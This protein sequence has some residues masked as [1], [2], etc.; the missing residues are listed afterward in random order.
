MRLKSCVAIAGTHGK[1]TTTSLVAALLDAGGLDPDG[2]QRR[3]HQRLRH[4]CAARRRRMD[5][6]RGRRIRRHF[7]QAA[8]RRCRRH[9]YRSRASRPLPHLRGGA[10]RVPHLRREHSVLRLR[11][12]VHRSSGGADA[13]RPA[14]RPARR[15]LRRKSA[16]RCALADLDHHNGASR[17][18][19][20]FRDRAGDTTHTIDNLA[21]PM[22][23]RHNALNATAAIAV[24][25]QLG[26]KRRRDPQGACQFRRRQAALHQ[27]G[28]VERRRHH[29][30]LRPSSGGNRRGAARRARK[31]P[32]ARSSR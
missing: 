24:A 28:R 11:G 8:G 5:G 15:H 27:S 1:T 14:R 22:P 9:Q 30:R 4:Q 2:D 6:G 32:R 29:R 26:I 25:H 17:F 7:P 3:H 19:V 16:G 12:D 31:R 21:L 18:S 23:G 20:V 10:G 13:G